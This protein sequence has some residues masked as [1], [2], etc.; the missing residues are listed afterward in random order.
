MKLRLQFPCTL[1][2]AV[3]F[4]NRPIFP[5][6]GI[7]LIVVHFGNVPVLYASTREKGIG[8]GRQSN[9]FRN[10]LRCAVI[11]AC[12]VPLNDALHCSDLWWEDEL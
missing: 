2:A 10:A 9:S 3:Y 11:A 6:A 5:K 4:Q 7:R 8:S 1:P 12:A